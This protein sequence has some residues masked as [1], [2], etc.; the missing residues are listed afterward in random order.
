MIFK[1][2]LSAMLALIV[3][4]SCLSGTV[5]AVK[6]DITPITPRWDYIPDPNT[7]D[8]YTP[9]VYFGDSSATE[10]PAVYHTTIED[11][12]AQLRERMEDRAATIIIGYQT[13]SSD[14]DK[15]REIFNKALEHTSVPT[16]GDYLRYQHGA[17]SIGLSGYETSGTYYITFKYNMTYYT[18]AAQE[19]QMD[20]AVKA[21]LDTLD[22][23]D[24]SDYEKVCAV[25]DYMTKN[26]VYDD[27]GLYQ[28]QQTG[29][30]KKIFTA[31]AAL[32]DG[33]SVCQGYAN[34][35][36][37]LTLELGVDSRII[38]G[39]GHS[40]SH[41]WN[42]V[43]LDNLYYDADATWDA[44]WKQAGLDYNYF[45]R[46]DNNFGDH[47]RNEEF[48][49]EEFLSA[50]P[51]ATA[52]YI[53]SIASGNCGSNLNWY[54][55]P[56]GAL[57]IYGEGAISDYDS[58]SA[59]PWSNYGK[60]ITSAI[61]K[62]GVTKIGNYAFS[63]YGSDTDSSS[64]ST[65][66]DGSDIEV[67]GGFASRGNN[68]L[69][70]VTIPATVTQIGDYAFY[71]CGALTTV[72]YNG[73]EAQWNAIAVG[74]GNEALENA[75]ILY[76]G[77]LKIANAAP[78]LYDNIAMNYKLNKTR[79]DQLG[80][81]DPYL[82]VAFNGRKTA[83]TDYTIS[84]DGTQYIFTFYNIAP[85]QMDDTL[86]A[87]VHATYGDDIY[88]GATL[89]YTVATYC[90]RM[91]SNSTVVNDAAY[92]ELRTLLVDL[93]HYGA[94][95][96]TFTGYT[97]DKVDTRLTET[98][99]SWG[100]TG[101]PTLEN[102]TS[103]K[104]ATIDNPTAVWKSVG[105]VLEDAVNIHLKLTVPTTENVI[106]KI[107]SDSDPFGWIIY[108]DNLSYDKENNCY[109]IDFGELHAGQMRE[110]VYATVY[111]G[112][113]AISNTLRYSIESY[114]YKYQNADA[115]AHPGLADLVKAM[116]V[117]GDAAYNFAN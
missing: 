59:M 79:F 37:R 4:I 56:E 70:S 64:P 13:T 91:L 41:A 10:A 6:D 106:L 71:K 66:P 57:T 105:L 30:N 49:T 86:T 21:L 36:Y 74:A 102:K 20:A 26:I 14:Y 112:E 73:T 60:Y 65:A 33:T 39:F 15:C 114:A 110:C 88:E 23:Y 83:I 111:Q 46:C 51:M 99:A 19:E 92:A 100:S 90:Y 9:P 95:A 103:T 78:T 50:Y 1:R 75:N 61:V 35:L 40:V 48:T 7:P 29:N 38:A 17:Y 47:V 63:F 93:L 72:I 116:M 45:L 81:T 87:T 97:G 42:I 18:T 31:Y 69:E 32:V 96:Q 98:Q 3:L 11:A 82:I 76:V 2:W 117:Y 113:T 107:T 24:A 101:T 5:F 54:L 104:Y 84:D 8:S 16:Q 80:I 52:D 22:V 44:S 108:G 12:A 94:A 109:Y 77:E 68:K 58:R 27:A 25:Y 55:T 115:V 28:E 67:D 62:E 43:E 53:P 34:L 89:N 85:N